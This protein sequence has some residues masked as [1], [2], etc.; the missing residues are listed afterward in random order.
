[1]AKIVFTNAY[2]MVNSVELSDHVRSVTIDLGTD[3]VEQTTMGASARNFLPGL[4]TQTISVT[5]ANDYAAS[6][7]DATIAPL[8]SAGTSHTI[9]I[10]PV[11]TTVG[12]TNPKYSGT[13]YCMSF[14]PASGGVGDLH[15]MTANW[16]PAT[17][18]GFVRA[19]S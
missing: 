10:R 12:S 1:M 7:V 14:N 3:E 2:V 4:K 13:A 15:E 8:V 16:V 5:F 6:N 18:T 9:E 11:N 17:G 19:T